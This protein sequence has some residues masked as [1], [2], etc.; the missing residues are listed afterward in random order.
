MERQVQERLRAA[1]VRFTAGRR[2]VIEG[3]TRADGPLSAA[4]LHAHLQ[5]RVPLS[6]LYRSLAVLETAGVV[7]PHHGARGV[8]RYE[9]AEWLAGHHH[10]TVCVDCG[11]VEDITLPAA[12]EREL[13]LL[14]AEAAAEEGF[15]A[16]DHSLEIEGRCLRCR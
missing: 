16:S 2:A 12:R 13:H 14:A 10:H 7:A 15:A 6:S 8:T 3:L 9:L 1:G 11:A 4:E 5:P